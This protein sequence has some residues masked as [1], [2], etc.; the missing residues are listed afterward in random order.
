MDDVRVMSQL[1]LQ[2]TGLND[3]SEVRSVSPNL[4][5]LRSVRGDMEHVGATV[6]LLLLP[7]T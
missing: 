4:G 7:V 1:L 3:D 6:L 2:G 5:F